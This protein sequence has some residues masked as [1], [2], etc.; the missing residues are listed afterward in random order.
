MHLVAFGEQV[1]TVSEQGSWEFLIF[2]EQDLESFLVVVNSIELPYNFKVF[3][4]K[5]T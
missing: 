3:T 4:L 1:A 5:I 2:M